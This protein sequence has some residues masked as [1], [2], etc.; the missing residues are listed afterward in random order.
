MRFGCGF[1]SNFGLGDQ[2]AAVIF[3]L[4]SI[5]VDDVHHGLAP[6]DFDDRYGTAQVFP[7]SSPAPPLTLGRRRQS[8]EVR[9]MVFMWEMLLSVAVE[10]SQH[11]ATLVR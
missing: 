10:H 9:S 2:S 3:I 4:S 7:G 6:K 1:F 11:I 8:F 5:G